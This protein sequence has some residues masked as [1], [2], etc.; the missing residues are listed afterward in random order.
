MH[1][2]DWLAA[3]TRGL[4][5]GPGEQIL[6]DSHNLVYVVSRFQLSTDAKQANCHLLG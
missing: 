5:W 6:S 2:A 1:R 3:L 4:S